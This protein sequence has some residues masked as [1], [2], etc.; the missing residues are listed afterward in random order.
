MTANSPV[1]LT[2]LL[3]AVEDA[4]K[5]GDLTPL[6]LLVGTLD[7]LK[8][9]CRHAARLRMG[10]PEEPSQSKIWSDVG[11]HRVRDQWISPKE[12]AKRLD[13]SIRT[14]SRRS[15]KPPYSAFCVPQPKRG[16]KVS[17][18]GLEE[19]MRRARAR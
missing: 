5:H 1:D 19:H 18:A 3:R 10:Q 15:T 13:V 11:S 14:L 8:A 12:A 9:K 17:E 4:C 6:L 16:F 7:A 2:P